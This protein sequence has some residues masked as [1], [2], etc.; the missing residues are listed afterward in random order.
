MSRTKRWKRGQERGRSSSNARSSGSPDP[1]TNRQGFSRGEIDDPITK[2][3]SFLLTSTT[4]SQ[5]VPV[6]GSEA[7]TTTFLRIVGTGGNMEVL[8]LAGRDRHANHTAWIAVDSVPV[9]SRSPQRSSVESNLLKFRV[10]IWDQQSDDS[11][12]LRR[13]SVFRAFGRSVYIEPFRPGRT[14]GNIRPSVVPLS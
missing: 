7:G 9:G 13:G 10:T 3:T 14:V 12:V 11:T 1:A 5:M 4:V 2:A 6:F 8:N